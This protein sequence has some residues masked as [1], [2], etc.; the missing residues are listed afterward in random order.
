MMECPAFAAGG[1]TGGKPIQEHE[2]GA[3]CQME[4]LALPVSGTG[5]GLDRIGRKDEQRAAFDNC[6]RGVRARKPR[7]IAID[8]C[9]SLCAKKTP[10]IRADA[11]FEPGLVP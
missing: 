4:F 1:T 7:G 2:T 11:E 9:R 3:V 8:L 10:C 5:E 6:A